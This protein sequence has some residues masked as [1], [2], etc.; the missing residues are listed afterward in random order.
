[1]DV[2]S[3]DQVPKG[4]ANTSYLAVR[5][6][7]RQ[8]AWCCQLLSSIHIK[9][10]FPLLSCS[11]AFIWPLEPSSAVSSPSHKCPN[12]FICLVLSTGQLI[13]LVLYKFPCHC[14][15][16]MGLS[17]T[18]ASIQH[19]ASFKV[20]RHFII[21]VS[22]WFL[23]LPRA[24]SPLDKETFPVKPFERF[25]RQASDSRLLGLTFVLL[26]FLEKSGR[27]VH[28]HSVWVCLASTIGQ[29]LCHVF[30]R[31]MQLLIFLTFLLFQHLV[32][33]VRTPLFCQCVLCRPYTGYLQQ[34]YN[35]LFKN[36][37][38]HSCKSQ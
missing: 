2:K 8:A 1:M 16:S 9:L 11:P 30:Q 12:R 13:V 10:S 7:M 6:W 35:S 22:T 15:L 31:K 5:V 18:E 23:K 28:F 17:F 21:H 36:T 27:E 32:W 20:C 25:I 33:S 38:H 37:E 29:V 26:S 4:L 19:C 14:Y 34:E 3:P 24:S